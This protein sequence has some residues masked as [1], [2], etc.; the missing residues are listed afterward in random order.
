[1][2]LG[3]ESRQPVCRDL[4]RGKRT[5][6][7]KVWGKE[8]EAEDEPDQ[9]DPIDCPPCD[10]ETPRER[11]LCVWCGQALEPGAAKLADELENWIVERISTAETGE[12]KHPLLETWQGVRSD[13]ETRAEPVDQLAAV[14]GKE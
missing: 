10:K 6:D 4:R 3:L 11:D 7:A 8:I 1:V 9:L 5:R 2:G 12:Q 13:P 14:L